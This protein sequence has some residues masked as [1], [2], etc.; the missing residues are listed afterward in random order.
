MLYLILGGAAV[1][2]CDKLVL[3]LPPLPA[4]NCRD[5]SKAHFYQF[6]VV[7]PADFYADASPGVGRNPAPSGLLV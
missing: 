6:G 2:R 4:E 5:G 7:G 1:Y 3:S